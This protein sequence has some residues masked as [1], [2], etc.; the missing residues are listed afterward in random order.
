MDSAYDLS[1]T[2]RAPVGGERCR[3]AAHTPATALVWAG[4]FVEPDT[5]VF[6]VEASRSLRVLSEYLGIDTTAGQLTAVSCC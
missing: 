6:H 4:V 3:S 1:L 5:T 2:S